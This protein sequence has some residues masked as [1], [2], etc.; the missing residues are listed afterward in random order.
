[1]EHQLGPDLA[2]QSHHRARI[3]HV[4]VV[5]GDV[6]RG[7]D[8]IRLHRDVGGDDLVVAARERMDQ[9]AADLSASPGDEDPHVRASSAKPGGDSMDRPRRPQQPAG[10]PRRG[11]PGRR[12]ANKGRGLPNARD[13]GRPYAGSGPRAEAPRPGH[14]CAL[15]GRSCC[16]RE[17]L[18]GSTP[19]ASICSCPRGAR[20]PA[21][22]VRRRGTALVDASRCSDRSSD[23]VSSAPRV[24]GAACRC[25]NQAL[26]T[27]RQ[28][29]EA[30]CC[31]WH[32]T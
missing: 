6:G 12:L 14:M 16:E 25:R 15:V 3:R 26:V 8:S 9:V 22:R 24:P 31:R 21:P 17:V 32:D 18:S 30:R 29:R 20:L 4:E 10:S 5:P 28:A 2:E 7:L 19:L 13:R 27:D 1:M 11:D 23:R